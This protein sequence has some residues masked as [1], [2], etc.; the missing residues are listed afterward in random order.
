MKTM[1]GRVRRVVDL[2]KGVMGPGI[3]MSACLKRLETMLKR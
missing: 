2:W 1:G 3:D